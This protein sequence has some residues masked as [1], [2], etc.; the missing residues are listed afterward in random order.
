MD[1]KLCL[2]PDL[3]GTG[4]NLR[5][6]YRDLEP[7]I[8]AD[9]KAFAEYVSAAPV[10][11]LLHSR[12]AIG[13]SSAPLTTIPSGAKRLHIFNLSESVTVYWCDDGQTPSAS[14]GFPLKPGTYQLYDSEPTSSLLFVAVGGSAEL[15]LAFYA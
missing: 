7:T 1:T 3:E 10:T 5:R 8:G 11:P 4:A 12:Q 15:A 2:M 6:R 14:L 9:N 13:T